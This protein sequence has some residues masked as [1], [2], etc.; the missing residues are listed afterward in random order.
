MCPGMWSSHSFSPVSFTLHLQERK[1]EAAVPWDVESGSPPLVFAGGPT[2]TS[3]PEPF[4][5]FFDFVLLGDGEEVL[6]SH[7][8]NHADRRTCMRVWGSAFESQCPLLLPDTDWPLL[9]MHTAFHPCRKQ[10]EPKA[11]FCQQAVKRP[12]D[13][14]HSV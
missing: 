3:N 10:T 9:P 11:C 14:Q 6:V 13:M 1:E 5:A 4:A 12:T 2:A 7:R 8:S